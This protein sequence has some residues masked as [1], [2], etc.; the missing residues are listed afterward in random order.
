MIGR[1]VL[2]DFPFGRPFARNTKNEVPLAGGRQKE[3][4]HVVRIVFHTVNA[5]HVATCAVSNVDERD[6]FGSQ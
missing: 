1:N 4:H 3:E 2:I 6:V 5:C